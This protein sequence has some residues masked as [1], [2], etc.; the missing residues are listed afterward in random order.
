M[1]RVLGC[2]ILMIALAM[3]AH[4][5]VNNSANKTTV[6]GTSIATQFSFNFIGV[7]SAYVKVLLT[8]SSGTQTLLTQGNGATQYQ[9]VLNQPVQGAIWGIGGTVTYNPSG[10]PIPVGSTLTIY[11]VLPLTQAINLQ[12]LSSIAVLGKGSET[13]LDTG[14]MQGQQINEQIS[15]A[16]VANIANSAP[17]LPLPPAAQI[18][19]QGI[20]ADGTGL[21]LVGCAVPS[22]GV[23][24]TAMQPVVD[25]ATL[26][27]GRQAFGLGDMATH[28]IG[29]GLQDDGGLCGSPSCV[30]VNT[31]SPT[32][33]SSNQSV[34]STFNLQNYI[35]TGPLT[36]T[37]P[38]ANT[39][40]SGFGFYVANLP[41]GGTDTFAIDSNDKFVGLSSG[42]SLQI[43][44]GAT[45][46]IYTDA[47]TAGT[48]YVMNLGFSPAT[49]S[50]TQIITPGSSSY[51]TPTN[52][53]KIVIKG[54]AGAGGGGGSGNP[55]VSGGA[56]GTTIFGSV[57]V[58]GG[59][60]GPGNTSTS[61]GPGGTGGTGG[62]GTAS[63]RHAGSNGSGGGG[64]AGQQVGSGGHGGSSPFGGQGG[65]GQN[66]I[67]GT[68]GKSCSGGGGAGSSGAALAAGGGGGSG[69]YFE[70]VIYNPAS[71]YSYTVGSGGSA[72][73]GTLAGGAGGPG[74][75]D[76]EAFSN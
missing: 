59:A 62:T 54:C 71:S 22:S 47:A 5:T 35:T 46:F 70:L 19:N 66:G 75:L 74:E 14:V 2:L 38:R 8:D 39:L 43:P 33:V 32:Q 61:G 58:G 40:W 60:G 6:P 41:T 63:I 25:A 31:S 7:A 64:A 26:A 10:T 18:A 11:R 12:N 28:G 20:C 65:G 69:E 44:T 21:N 24:S 68:A 23:I 29:S 37:L 49:S 1:K 55:G 50:V 52:S 48:W 67:G 56:G 34:D 45:V 36:F 73:T 15:R 17:P 53:T 9:I 30:R 42:V 51:S 76:I 4:G 16:I 57:Q 3:P 27:L 72:G 13:G